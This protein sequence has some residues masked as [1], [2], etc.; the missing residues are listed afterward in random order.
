MSTPRFELANGVQWPQQALSESAHLFYLRVSLDDWLQQDGP[1][2]RFS[3]YFTS[4]VWT[5]TCRMGTPQFSRDT[6]SALLGFL[7]P[8]RAISSDRLTNQSTHFP[9]Q[10]SGAPVIAGETNLLAACSMFTVYVVREVPQPHA[11]P[12]GS[13]FRRPGP[14]SDLMSVEPTSDLTGIE[15]RSGRELAVVEIRSARTLAAITAPG[16]PPIRRS[17]DLRRYGIR[18]G[19]I[20]R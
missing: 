11:S 16:L 2:T 12:T 18:R 13:Q 15:T 3:T 5:H 10:R 9:T 8:N 1:S 6:T 17:A 20:L 14:G 19:S 7:M 4:V